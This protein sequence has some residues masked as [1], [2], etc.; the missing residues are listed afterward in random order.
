MESEQPAAVSET[1]IGVVF[2][3]GDL[4]Y[5][6][7]KPVRTGFLD[8][9][10]RAE[11]E[12]A[13]HRETELNRRFSPDVYLGVADISGPDGRP[14]DHLVV[15]RRMPAER[16]L[17][18]LVRTGASVTDALG[19]VARRLAAWHATAPRGPEISAE[20]RSDALRGRWTASF[21]D[22][23]AFHGTV[24]DAA[25]ATEIEHLALR[26]LDGREALFDRRVREG[27]IVDGHGDLIADD[28]FCLDDGPRILD[29]LEFDDRLRWLDGLDD[30]AFL[31]MDL[32]RLSRDDLAR[33]FLDRYAGHAGDPAPASLRHHY[34]AYRAFVR[35][36]VA[37]LRAAQGAPQAADDARRLA[38]LALRHLRA[39]AVT[40][41]LTGGLPGTGKTSLAGALADRLGWT[42]LSSDRVRKELAG[43]PPEKPA[44]A[45][46]GAGIYDAGST[47]RTY[48]E[49][50]DRAE[51]LLGEGESVIIDASW[52]AREHQDAAAALAER[53]HADLAALRCSVPAGTAADRIRTRTRGASDAD[54]AIA[55][56]MASDADP[57]P[58]AHVI[59]T[60]GPVAESLAQALRVVR[61][62]LPASPP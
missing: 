30:A 26:F 55:D 32:E 9:R 13:C 37:C 31:A 58:A 33:D 20:G 35:V 44:A 17:S 39:G 40:L 7:K 42:V 15:M 56:A 25:I 41:V 10:D 4:A 18:A 29:C 60:G 19:E 38:R 59:D 36:K 45:P 6:L 50:L 51:T 3:V 61:P 28:V 52:T 43:I 12:A 5:K 21:S 34:L 62:H 23:R 24:L 54:R 48:A 11:R 16:R 57:W 53:A 2:F 46:Y 27:R 14:C 1:H 8:F 22:V 47:E 49:L